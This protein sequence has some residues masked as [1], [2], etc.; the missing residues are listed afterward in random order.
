MIRWLDQIEIP[1]IALIRVALGGYF[2]YSGFE[3][4]ADPMIFLKNIHLYGMLPEEPPFFLNSVAAV[5]PWLEVVCGAALVIGIGIRGAAINLALMLCVFTPAILI[6]ALAIRAESGT[7]FFEIA[8]DCGC[9]SGVVVTWRKLGLNGVLILASLLV[10]FS[11]SRRLCL[12][13]LWARTRGGPALCKVCGRTL[14]TGGVCDC[15]AQVDA[16]SR[17]QEAPRARPS[18]DTANLISHR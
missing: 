16:D 12:S 10:L 14:P 18:R 7:P 15:T 11:R 8:F 17:V 6:R 13:R 5:L 2:I 1:L 4:I 9:G 3:K